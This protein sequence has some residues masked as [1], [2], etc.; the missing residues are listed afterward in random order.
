MYSEPCQTSTKMERFGNYFHN[1]N[2]SSSLLYEKKYDF[3]NA[4]LICIPEVFIQCKVWDPKEEEP[5]A[6]N[7]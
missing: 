5:A 3:F 2:F 1:S 4:G 7:F 6:V